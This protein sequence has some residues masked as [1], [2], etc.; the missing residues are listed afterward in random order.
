[1][2]GE[3]LPSIFD[4]NYRWLANLRRILQKSKKRKVKRLEIYFGLEKLGEVKFTKK[5]FEF[6]ST[7]DLLTKFLEEYS[8]EVNIGYV[9]DVKTGK[10]TQDNHYILVNELIKEGYKVKEIEE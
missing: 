4:I 7:F 9:E 10:I 2:I 8:K 3:F 6:V 5:G 1:M